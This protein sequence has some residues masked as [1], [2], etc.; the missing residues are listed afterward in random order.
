MKRNKNISLALWTAFFVGLI[1][2]DCLGAENTGVARQHLE[3][4]KE[5]YQNAKC[6][7]YIT[8]YGLFVSFED[9]FP[10]PPLCGCSCVITFQWDPPSLPLIF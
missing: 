3:E 6:V 5:V 1:R 9:M 10:E 4:E 2:S 7:G 8:S